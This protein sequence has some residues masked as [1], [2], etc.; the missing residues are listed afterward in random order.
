MCTGTHPFIPVP[1]T[2]RVRMVYSL[3]GQTIMNVFNY[4]QTGPFLSADL[5][6]LNSSVLTEWSANLKPGMSNQITLEYIEST[7]LDTAA[8]FQETLA[9][10]VVGGRAT[11]AAPTGVTLAIKFASGLIGR[12]Q[13]GR[14]YVVGSCIAD[15]A[16]DQYDNVTAAAILS[17]YTTFF[18]NIA[19]TTGA[20]HVVVSYCSGG[21]WRTTGQT[22]PV[23]NYVL[24]DNNIDSQRRRL[25]GRGM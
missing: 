10:G 9:V 22:T 21:V 6:A 1:N 3:F 4:E 11:P 12:S 2:A 8:G 20:N 5:I 25:A 13:R 23:T 14:I 16:G 7:A 17:N 15:L 24:T 18:N 19:A